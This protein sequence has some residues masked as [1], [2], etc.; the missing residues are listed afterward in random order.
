MISLELLISDDAALFSA[1][2]L[3]A[4]ADLRHDGSA[5]ETTQRVHPVFG[6]ALR[7]LRL[8]DYPGR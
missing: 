3:K 4:V 6:G 8:R 7:H 5:D 1:Q 2:I